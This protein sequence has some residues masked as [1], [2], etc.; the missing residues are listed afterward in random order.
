M[1]IYVFFVY[2]NKRR[3]RKGGGSDGFDGTEM[4]MDDGKRKMDVSLKT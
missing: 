2:T 3:Y 1:C 4:K